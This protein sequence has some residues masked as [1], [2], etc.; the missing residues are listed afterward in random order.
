MWHWLKLATI[1]L[2]CIPVFFRSR[3]GQAI[4]ELTLRQQLTT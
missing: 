1:F 3:G 2:R 4:V